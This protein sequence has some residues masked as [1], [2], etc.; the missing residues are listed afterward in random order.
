MKWEKGFTNGQA[1]KD[2]G[3]IHLSYT[4]GRT[5]RSSGQHACFVFAPSQFQ[6]PKRQLRDIYG[7]YF[8]H[9]R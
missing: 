7:V 4:S 9:Y 6:T 1:H 3:H 5:T 8:V 2:K